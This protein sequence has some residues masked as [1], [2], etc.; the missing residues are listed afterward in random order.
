MQGYAKAH[1][2][3]NEVITGR[4]ASGESNLALVCVVVIALASPNQ[5][6]D[7]LSPCRGKD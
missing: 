6:H 3:H 2:Y 7:P 5:E 1:Y 4:A